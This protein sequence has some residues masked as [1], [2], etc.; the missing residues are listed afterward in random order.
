MQFY[1]INSFEKLKDKLPFEIDI[2][3][4]NLLVI[5]FKKVNLKKTN[6]MQS[7]IV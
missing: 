2:F 6:N 3:F 1:S 4:F 7:F 5:D